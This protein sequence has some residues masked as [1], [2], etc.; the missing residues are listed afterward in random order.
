VRC[1]YPRTVGYQSDGQTLAWSEK[2]YSK[3]YPT[4][5][6]PCGKCLECRLEYARSTAIRCVHE[7]KMYDQNTFLT[8]TY[9]DERLESPK[10]I[11]EHIQTFIKDLRSKRLNDHLKALGMK[12]DEYQALDTKTRQELYKPIMMP[13]MTTGEYGEEKKRPHWHLL[14]FNWR[15]EDAQYLRTNELG[16]KLYKS[17]WVDEQWGRNDPEQKPNEIGDITFRSAGYVARYA[18]KKL[19]HGNDQD[20]NYHPIHRRSSRNAIGKRFLEKYW[21]DIFN[22]GRCIL[23]DGQSCPIP[24]YYEKW[25]QKQKPEEWVKYLINVKYPKTEK[26]EEK[27]KKEQQQ[28]KENYE[29]RSVAQGAEIT[30]NQIRKKLIEERTKRLQQHQKGDI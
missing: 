1:I 9:K 28:Y 12:R 30:K 25:L 7:A 2:K 3:E 8:L 13:I 24:R 10:L 21:K 19:V 5:Q 23:S 18:T 29:K 15:P 11:Y 4:F 16:D 14:I 17:K 22:H 27:E 20:H 26:A 6:L